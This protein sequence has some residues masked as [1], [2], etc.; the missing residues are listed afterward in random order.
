MF[1]AI[2]RKEYER[3]TTFDRKINN[4]IN[5]ATIAPEEETKLIRELEELAKVIPVLR[6]S[7]P[8]TR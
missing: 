8:L 7:R 6:C 1:Q 4:T 3:T 5:V 2:Q